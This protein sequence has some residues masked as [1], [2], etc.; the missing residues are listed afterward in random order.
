MFI[1]TE[2]SAKCQ[3]MTFYIETSFSESCLPSHMVN[4]CLFESLL[5]NITIVSPQLQHLGLS[6]HS[7]CLLEVPLCLSPMRLNVNASNSLK[8]P[9]FVYKIVWKY[10]QSL[11]E[12]GVNKH[13]IQSMKHVWWRGLCC[14]YTKSI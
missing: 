12:S 3:F 11:L 6:C 4:L 1:C 14:F 2:K 7:S 8:L 10:C 9:A 5:S 13:G